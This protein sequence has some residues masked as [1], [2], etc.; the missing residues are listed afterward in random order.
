ML[1]VDTP[2]NSR[3]SWEHVP[4]TGEFRFEAS[5]CENLCKTSV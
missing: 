2:D 5:L 3:V 4:L 1:A